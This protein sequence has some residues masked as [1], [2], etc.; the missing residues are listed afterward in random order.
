MPPSSDRVVSIILAR[1][2][3]NRFPDKNI[4]QLG[5]KRLLEWV[6]SAA[7]ESGVI[8]KVYVS[9]DSERYAE[10]TKTAGAFPIMRPAELCTETATSE[11]ALGHALAELSAAGLKPKVAVL[12]QPTTPLTEPSTIRK[13]VA[14]V[15]SGFETSTSI[16]LADKKPW[17]AFKMDAEGRLEHFL[18]LPKD[19]PY[20]MEV[21]PPLYYPTGGVYAFNTDYFRR[22]HKVYG[23][24]A[25]GVLVQ[26]YEAIDIDYEQDLEFARFAL[27]I[28][29][30]KNERKTPAIGA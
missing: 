22:T 9:T 12:Q 2:G 14:A 24:Q 7:I 29:Q 21:P 30:E 18:V 13:A 19:S 20:N 28:I 16:V 5:P 27:K 11:D 3:S 8:S 1:S 26:W 25:Y 23:G 15:Q 10:I 4:A 6:I 17:W